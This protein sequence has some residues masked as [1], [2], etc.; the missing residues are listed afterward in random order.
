MRFVGVFQMADARILPPKQREPIIANDHLIFLCET[1]LNFPV[2]YLLKQ[3][4][5]FT[6]NYETLQS[7]PHYFSRLLSTLFRMHM[8]F[9]L[10]RSRTDVGSDR[11]LQRHAGHAT[12]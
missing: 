2:E 7:Q 4:T 12:V 10:V 9:G 5:D 11:R 8:I 1:A 3:V 6:R